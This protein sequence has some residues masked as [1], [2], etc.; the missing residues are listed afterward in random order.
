MKNL[1]IKK[2]NKKDYENTLKILK[3]QKLNTIC[4]EANCPNRYECFSKK[5]ATFLVLGN[6][7][8]RNCK[9]CNVETGQ[10]KKVNEKEIESI[11][12]AIKKL[13]LN[14]VVL[15]QVTRDDLKDG[16]ASHISKIIKKI[17][18]EFP[19][20]KIEILISD[21]K[22]NWDALKLICE[23]KP[24]VINHNIETVK[25]KFNELRPQGNYDFSLKLLK[26]IKEIDPKINTKSGLMVGL[27]E[28]K[29][30]IIKTLNDLKRNK[31]EFITIGQY[32]QPN[33]EK[34]KTTKVYS[35]KEFKRL[36]EIGL[37]IGF[38]AVES[39]LLVRSSYNA[40]EMYE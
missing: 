20:I 22:N 5:T 29:K 10:P 40:G 16:G 3:K 7:C 27:G 31:V 6:I 26:K 38:N 13:K 24:D 21:L 12:K 33:P 32:L 25:E 17:K 2:F 11:L 9:Y 36:K 34:T 28:T 1:K 15:T 18:K 39:G 19:K 30:Q 23:A 37:K 35:N 8:S 4:L 14:Y